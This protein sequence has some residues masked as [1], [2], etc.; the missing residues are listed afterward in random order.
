[1]WGNPTYKVGQ[2][3]PIRLV[4]WVELVQMSVPVDLGCYVTGS[5]SGEL[6]QTTV[7]SNKGFIL[8]PGGELI[9]A[10]LEKTPLGEIHWGSASL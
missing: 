1:M 8:Q 9:L 2:T 7:R 3:S 5:C 6:G 10:C 4:F